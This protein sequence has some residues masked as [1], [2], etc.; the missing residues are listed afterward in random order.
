[1]NNNLV[2]LY[3]NSFTGGSKNTQLLMSYLSNEGVEIESFFFK[4]PYHNLNL[5]ENIISHTI[6][7]LDINNEVINEKLIRN[8]YYNNLILEK[9]RHK[10]NFSLFG[11]YL[12]PYCDILHD[13]KSQ[14]INN[15]R[16]KPRLILHPAGSDIWQIGPQLRSKV[17]WLL[18]SPL[19]D[20][21]FTYSCSFVNEIKEYYDV[22]KNIDVIPPILQKKI[23][24][25]LPSEKIV[26]RKKSLGF[27]EEDF[28]IHHHSSMK[29]IKCPEIVVEISKKA[30]ELIKRKC[31]LIL[32]GP[33]QL[34]TIKH[35]NL[36]LIKIDDSLHFKYK[37]LFGNLLI[38]WTGIIQSV[39]Y[40][41]QISDVEINSSLHDSFNISLM[42]AIACGVPVITSDIVGIK[43]HIL[44]SEAG[45]CFPTKKL[46]FDE[47]NK[48]I[49]EYDTKRRCFDIDYAIS[50][51]LE[52]ANKPLKSKEMG[53][54]GAK[55]VERKFTAEKAI[56][57]FTKFIQ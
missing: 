22:K 21:V 13:I 12:F 11:E 23:F 40:L 9:V 56:F 53:N 43:K 8:Y 29:R 37:T 2:T 1:M 15:Y 5:N 24:Y 49:S 51:V 52:I 17:K 41:L 20:N 25:P 44:K 28:V 36:E 47:L 32:S 14:L 7:K 19:V 33:I 26:A 6:N 18:D 46:N 42:E 3:H 54:R 31:I 39:E 50:L 55:Y 57:D 16:K 30:S 45:F 48:V 35:L 10:N 34:E 27:N 4:N 38:L